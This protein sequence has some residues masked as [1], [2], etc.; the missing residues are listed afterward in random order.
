MVFILNKPSSFELLDEFSTGDIM[1]HFLKLRVVCFKLAITKNLVSVFL[2][3]PPLFSDFFK[4]DQIFIILEF[5]FGGADLENSN[6][7]VSNAHQRDNIQ[8]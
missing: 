3:F 2:V 1:I 8:F 7:K 6:G 4:K 5:E